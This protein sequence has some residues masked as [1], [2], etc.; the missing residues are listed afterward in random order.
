MISKTCILIV[1]CLF[2]CL[3]GYSE[4]ADITEAIPV[5]DADCRIVTDYLGHQVEVKGDVEYIGSLFAIAS[6]IT[7]ML[8]ESESIVTIP[9]GNIRDILFCE[10]YPAITN[11]RVVKG[12]NT[13][14]IEEIARKPRPEV[15][16]VNPEIARDEGQMRQL[17]KLNAPIIT[18]AYDTVEEQIA[19]VK[20]IGEVINRTEKAEA[21]A[22]YYRTVLDRI[23]TRTADIPPEEKKTV[24]HA[25]NELL[26]TDQKNTLSEDWLNRIGVKNVAFADDGK[27]E[28]SLSKNY[29]PLEVLLEKN[30]EYIIINGGEVYDY[31]EE[32]P[33]LH[34]LK[35]YINGNIH[36]LPLGITRWG[37]PTSIETPLA[38][39]WTA[40]LVYP[41]R[42]E[43]V[44]IE[45]ETRTFY[46][47]FFNY[48]LSDKQLKKI[49]SG[50]GYKKIK[51]TGR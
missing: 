48:D 14:N 4:P 17:K 5:P 32:S 9:Q 31:I 19:M 26:R 50:R 51:G 21:Y 39:L 12:S 47:T 37:H 35:A 16:F 18:I 2:V 1:S 22:A 29:M 49:L 46:S 36:L 13:V 34:H 20:L 10:I 44:D 42:F 40:K 24:Y 15:F 30:P 23:A 28:L 25:I 27:E 6:H 38:M 3:T 43:D 8:G 7:A 41:E 11:A 33:Q 45:Q